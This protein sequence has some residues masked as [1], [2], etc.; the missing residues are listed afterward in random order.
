MSQLAQYMRRESLLASLAIVLVFGASFVFSFAAGG[1]DTNDKTELAERQ[2]FIRKAMDEHMARIR[3][4]IEEMARRNIHPLM[5]ITTL[6]PFGDWDFYFVNGGTIT[7]QPNEGQNLQRVVVPHGFVTDL[8][9]IP[10]VFW[11]VLRPEGRYA[12]A[13]VVHDYLYWTQTRPR[14]EADQIFKFAME[15]SKVDS[16]TVEVIYQAVRSFGQGSWDDNARLRKAGECRFLKRVPQDFTTSWSDWKKQ[17][18]VFSC[19]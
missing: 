6:T 3:E 13:A 18:D 10:R 4:Q 9:S 15:D 7:W 19:N 11:Q 8:T 5:I 2:E 12:Y 14:E 17:P 16:K 1:A